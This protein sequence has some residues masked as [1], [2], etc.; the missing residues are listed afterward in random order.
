MHFTF[1]FFLRNYHNSTYYNPT[2]PNLTNATTQHT[3]HHRFN[4]RPLAALLLVLPFTACQDDDPYQINFDEPAKELSTPTLLGGTALPEIYASP[5]GMVVGKDGYIYVSITQRASNWTHPA[6]IA[7]ISPDDKISDFF[8]LPV[9]EITGKALPM[10]L[11]FADDGNLYYSD[12]QSSVVKDPGQSSLNRIIVEDGKPVRAEKVAVGINA[13]NG[14]TRWKDHIYVAEPDLRVPGKNLSGVYRFAISELNAETPVR[15]TGVGDPHLILTL[16]TK[17]PKWR[18]ANGIGFDSKGNLYVNN[19]GDA[20]VMK[21]SFAS[22]NGAITTRELFTRP[23]GILTVDGRQVDKDDNLWIA[24]I[25][26]NAILKVSTVSG[27]S[28]I[29]AKNGPSTGEDGALDT[30]SECIRRGN[31]VYVSNIDLDFPPSATDSLQ[32]ISVIT[33]PEEKK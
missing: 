29:I 23:K 20:E 28:S 15:V 16:E 30:P 33:L 10:G 12:N 21:Y 25:A 6:R 26:G 14:I 4:L 1:Y 19:F 13:A 22:D 18:G 5:D 32:S 31:K 9:H 11:V 3:M 17:N 2:Q 8:V 27:R 24:D 7:R